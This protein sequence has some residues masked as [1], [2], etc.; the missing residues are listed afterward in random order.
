MSELPGSVPLVIRVRLFAMLRE[1]AG[2]GSLE[3][4][5]APG[6]TVADA[7]AA[8]E[9]DERLAE[10]LARL[11]LRLAVNRDY[12]DAT[13]ELRAGD[14][15]ALIPPVSGGAGGGPRV[16]VGVSAE[17]LSADRLQRLVAD[18]GAG[19]LVTFQGVTRRVERLH[20]ETYAEMAE[21]QLE[22]IARECLAA[23]DLRR[24]AI[25]HRVGSV[26]L[27]EP[28]VIV[29]VS[30]AHREQAFAAARAAIDEIKREAPIWKREHDGPGPGRWVDPAGGPGVPAAEETRR[31]GE[32]SGGARR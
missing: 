18:P 28:S 12:A 22:R 1:R 14:E 26:P 15:L 3:L 27:G 31:S 2:S 10:L 9:R 29:A 6:A 23:H 24:I 25:E 7:L 4:R 13:T 30:A 16:H 8:L 11:P 19:A 17:P 5:L 32:R 21:Q 20:Y